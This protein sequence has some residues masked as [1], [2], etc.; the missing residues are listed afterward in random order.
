MSDPDAVRA[1]CDPRLSHLHD[2]GLLSGIDA[3]AARLALALR[4]RERIAIYGDYDVDGITASA[5][6]FHTLRTADPQAVVRCYVPHRVDEGYG[7]HVEA[8][9]LLAQEGATA[10]VTVDCGITAVEPARLARQLGMDLIVTDHHQPRADGVLPDAHAVVHPMLRGDGGQAYPFPDLC[11]AGVAFKLA[12]RLATHWCGGERVSE[13]FR[14]TLMEMLPLVALGTIADVVPLRGENR[15]LASA[16]LR[17]IRSSPLA[18]LQALIQESGLAG[19]G[20]DCEKVGFVLAPRLNA[21]GRLGHAAAALRLFTDAGPDEAEAIAAELTA[22]NRQ[23]QRTE[24]AIAAEACAMAVAQGQTAEGHRAIVL[25][26]EAWHP[27]VIGIVCSR[28]VERFGRPTILLAADGEICRGSGRSVEGYSLHDGLAACAGWLEHFGGHDAAAGLAVKRENFDAFR[29]AF[30]QHVNDRLA[31]TDLVPLLD[32]DCE[33]VLAEM[34]HA[35]V[36]E[37]ARLS[38]FGRGNRRPTILV[39][40][41]VVASQPR[42]LKE[43]HLKLGLAAADSCNGSAPGGGRWSRSPRELSAIWWNAAAQAP[44]LPRGRRLDVVAEPRISSWSGQVELE[45]RDVRCG[46]CG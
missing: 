31:P 15:V 33:A 36:G 40:D 41:L 46:E 45:I 11:G 5:I 34:D 13:A 4:R 1:F 18:G 30:V 9:T 23:R 44:A 14:T 38:P 26:H 42:V 19:E 2:P 28:L 20:I 29:M 21:C 27:G 43:R 25:A 7:L 12:W 16:G 35:A 10:V 32:I 8:L 3:A 17:A 24:Q 37:L 22:L 6:L 39:R